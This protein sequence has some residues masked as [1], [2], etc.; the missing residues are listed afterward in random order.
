MLQSCCCWRV[1][2]SLRPQLYTAGLIAAESLVL[3]GLVLVGLGL[4]P[5]ITGL[6]LVSF[7][8]VGLVLVGV[9]LGLRPAT[10]GLGLVGFGLGV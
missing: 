4:R 1:L 6:S 2:A 3:V 9:G 10:T 8:L 7:V 5:A